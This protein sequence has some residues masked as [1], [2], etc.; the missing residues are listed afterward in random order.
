MRIL[1][2][3][4]ILFGAI[5]FLGEALDTP[6]DRR[7]REFKA[8]LCGMSQ[9]ERETVIYLASSKEEQARYMAAPPAVRRAIMRQAAGC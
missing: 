9:A 7:R 5:W 4:A 1:L 6:E 2:G 3:L 8:K